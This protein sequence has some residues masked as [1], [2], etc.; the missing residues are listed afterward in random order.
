MKRI[1]GIM[2]LALSLGGCFQTVLDNYAVSE[3]YPA[4]RTA[5]SSCRVAADCTN[6]GGGGGN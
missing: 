2:A 1:L 3:R 6:D 4:D 5:R